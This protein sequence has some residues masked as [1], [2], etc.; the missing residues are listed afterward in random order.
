MNNIDIEKMKREIK[1]KV[2]GTVVF[3]GLLTLMGCGKT[4]QDTVVTPE[5][6]TTIETVVE[7]EDDEIT[8]PTDISDNEVVTP[9]EEEK[10][11]PEPPFVLTGDNQYTVYVNCADNSNAEELK[12]VYNEGSD[13]IENSHHFGVSPEL[14]A[15]VLAYGEKKWGYK[16]N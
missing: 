4:N 12:T 13:I 8:I 1:V 10:E 15:A 16:Y 11:L 5:P 9:V 7:P 2:G 14:T 3:F 6:D